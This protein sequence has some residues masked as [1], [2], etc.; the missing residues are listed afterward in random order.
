MNF[1][2]LIIRLFCIHFFILLILPLAKSQGTC[3]NYSV[4]LYDFFGDGWDNGFLTIN[5]N[6]SAFQTVTLSNGF[7]PVDFVFPTDSGDI[8]D[9][10]F[11]AGFSPDDNYY[12]VFGEQNDTLFLQLPQ[13]NQEAPESVYNIQACPTCPKPQN[14]NTLI[15]TSDF[16]VLDWQSAGTGLI[17]EIEF[18][19]SGYTQGLGTLVP[20]VA[21]FPYQLAGLNS[22]TTYDFYV[23]EICS[24]SDS[25]LWSGPLSFAT[26][27]TAGNC[28]LFTVRLFDSFGD[29]WDENF[30]SVEVNNTIVDSITV[31]FGFGPE[32]FQI[33]VDSNDIVNLTYNGGSWENEDSYEV[34]YNDDVLFQPANN[35]GPSSSYGLIACPSDEVCG[36]YSLILSTYFISGSP[37]LNIEINNS[38][39]YTTSWP[40]G[41]FSNEP[42]SFLVNSADEINL[43]Y[44]PDSTGIASYV[45]YSLIDDL[46]NTIINEFAQDS[47]GPNSTYGILACQEYSALDEFERLIEPIIYPNPANAFLHIESKEKINTIIIT[48]LLGQKVLETSGKNTSIDVSQLPS[49]N[50]IIEILGDNRNFIKKI[51]IYH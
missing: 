32:T 21:S 18:G 49:N 29:G 5:K 41:S 47:L 22:N 4:A 45:G 36:A 44:Q 51:I 30:I 23:R 1:L 43:V 33:P 7:G 28:G 2:A 42:F 26:S 34:Y 27:Q 12:Y 40:T 24:N 14:L 46:G 20:N 31:E 10:L 9:I 37:A 35:D 13:V 6:G 50:Y 39:E 11:T 16:A 48:N 19:P 8:I 25:S 17:W 15:I 38:L 3:G